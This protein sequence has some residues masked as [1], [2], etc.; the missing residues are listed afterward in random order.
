MPYVDGTMISMKNIIEKMHAHSSENIICLS[1]NIYLQDL[2]DSL[3]GSVIVKK[4][5]GG[6]VIEYFGAKFFHGNI[7]SHPSLSG[8]TI[9]DV[10]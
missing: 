1:E 10:C 9:I 5:D 2:L 8:R 6:H 7:T 3:E 4:L